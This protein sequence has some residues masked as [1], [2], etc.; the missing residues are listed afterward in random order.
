MTTKIRGLIVKHLKERG[1]KLLERNRLENK[2]FNTILAKENEFKNKLNEMG[3]FYGKEI[4]DLKTKLSEANASIDK[5]KENKI[6]LQENLKRALMRGVVAMNLEAMNILEPETE[7][8]NNN[9]VLNM[10]NNM[11]D[12]NYFNKMSFTDIPNLN[13]TNANNNLYNNAENNILNL[14]NSAAKY[15]SENPEFIYKNNTSNKIKS[16]LQSQNNSSSN[17][18][19]QPEIL[20]KK[21]FF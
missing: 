18:N 16:N 10:A 5:Y 19:Y 14:N 3:Q 9:I 8:N 17:I 4:S 11:V 12:L 7:K 15:G 2:T 20:E 21:V 13:N 6:Y 1:F